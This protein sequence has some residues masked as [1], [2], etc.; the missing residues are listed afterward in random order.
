[1]VDSPRFDP[2]LLARIEALG[3]ARWI[4]L[5]HR[6]DVADHA[7]WASKLGAKRILH[8]SECNERQGTDEVEVKLEGEGPWTLRDCSGGEEEGESGGETEFVLQPGHTEACVAMFHRPSKALFSGDVISCGASEGW[9]M[10]DGSP[11]LHAYR[12]FCWFSFSKLLDSVESGLKPLPFLHLLPG[13]G[14]SGSW[15]SFEQKDAAVEEL[16]QREREGA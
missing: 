16:L 15:E 12:D 13:H 3:G 11:R 6:D 9:F 7:R 10:P 1:M 5:T 2:K 14:R 4:F 8:A